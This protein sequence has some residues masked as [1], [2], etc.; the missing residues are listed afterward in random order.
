MKIKYVYLALIIILLIISISQIF[1]IP[2][3]AGDIYTVYKSGYFKELDRGFGVTIDSFLN[4]KMF[5]KPV[6]GWIFLEDMRKKFNTNIK[7]Y[8]NK[9]LEIPAPGETEASKDKNII[10][11][12]NSINPQNYSVIQNGKYYSAIPIFLEDRCRFCHT[13]TNK[14]NI[15]GIMTF[16]RDYDAFIYY[17][18]ER[19]IIFVIIS[20]VLMLLLYLIIKWD[21][22]KVIK[23][24]FDK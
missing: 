4:I 13:S 8:N 22:G 11:I 14:K 24:L 21:P 12:I 1:T 10:K 16:E 5:S 3:Y 20:L 7:V 6:Y 23:E 9:G 15:A 17:S 19:I 18:S 2:P